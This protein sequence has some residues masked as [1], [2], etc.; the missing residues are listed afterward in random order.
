MLPLQKGVPR[1]ALLDHLIHR[2]VRLERRLGGARTQDLIANM[3]SAFNQPDHWQGHAWI[4][5]L[6]AEYYDPRYHFAFERSRKK[7][8]FQGDF[9]QCLQWIQSN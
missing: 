2:L 3:N 7:V 5:Q 9:Q 4:G 8:V 1:E 6:L